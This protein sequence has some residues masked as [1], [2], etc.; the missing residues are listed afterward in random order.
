MTLALFVNVL[1]IIIIIIEYFTFLK[2]KGGILSGP[3]D[4]F[5]FNLFIAATTPLS[6]KTTVSTVVLIL[7]CGT[8][9]DWH[10]SIVNYTHR[11]IVCIQNI[12]FVLI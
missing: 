12:S 9:A 8:M 3:E 10:V 11:S 1:I 6:E 5:G 2:N 7:K 4:R